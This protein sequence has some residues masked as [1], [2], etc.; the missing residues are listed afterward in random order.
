MLLSKCGQKVDQVS[1]R[2]TK[3][4]ALVRGL[5]LL[6]CL[7]LVA[8]AATMLAGCGKSAEQQLIDNASHQSALAR[9]MATK[10]NIHT[11]YVGL[12][13]YSVDNSD[14]YPADT[15]PL[16]GASG[17]L[18]SG[19]TVYVESWPENPY[20]NEPMVS[21]TGPGD[22]TYTVTSTS[23]ELVGYGE[24]GNVIITVP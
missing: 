20:T 19:S 16:G 4:T 2:A 14:S 18:T 12:T 7:A 1:A 5:L 21:G 22:Y 11:I 17:A 6:V 9:E 24:D 3:P 23:F 10:E 15:A 8:T 13:T